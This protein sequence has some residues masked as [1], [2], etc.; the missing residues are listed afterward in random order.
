MRKSPLFPAERFL[1]EYEKLNKEPSLEST[2]DQKKLENNERKKFLFKKVNDF[3][4][5]KT[6]SFLSRGRV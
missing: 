5:S 6:F 4:F 2:K 1:E 3:W